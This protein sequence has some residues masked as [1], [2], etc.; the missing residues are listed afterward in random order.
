MHDVRCKGCNKLLLKAVTFV[1][2][3]KCS[4]CSMI[5][6]YKVLT[7][8]YVTTEFDMEIVKT[9]AIEKHK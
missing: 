6:E 4:R 2:A 8:M 5:F 7:N 1:G 9:L 3:V